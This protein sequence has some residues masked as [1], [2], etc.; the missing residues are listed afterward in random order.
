M[1][2]ALLQEQAD[3]AALAAATAKPT[4]ADDPKQ[5]DR[6]EESPFAETPRAAEGWFAQSL[7]S[8]LDKYE[9]AAELGRIAPQ[10]AAFAP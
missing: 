4:T 3:S 9:S 2:T 8:A 5:D 7:L 6:P 10:T 1:Q